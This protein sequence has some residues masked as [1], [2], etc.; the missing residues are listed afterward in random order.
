M[1]WK[2]KGKRKKMKSNTKYQIPNTFYLPTHFHTF[3]HTLK[4]LTKTSDGILYFVFYIR[5]ELSLSHNTFHQTMQKLCSPTKSPIIK[6]SP[7]KLS[8]FHTFLHTFKD[9]TKYQMVFCILYFTSEPKFT[10]SHNTFQ[11]T[12]QIP[13]M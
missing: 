5:A 8:H 6:P 13:T 10:L 1:R 3:L 9:L 2:G 4:D 7:H 11:Q 12:M